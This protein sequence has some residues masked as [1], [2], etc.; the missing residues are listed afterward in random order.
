MEF[1]QIPT[2][3]TGFFIMVFVCLAAGVYIFS[4]VRK[5][6]MSVLRD[7][8]KDL[9]ATLTDNNTRI[10]TLESETKLLITKVTTLEQ[11]N[12]T[13]EDLVVTALK[14]YFFENPKVASNIK[15]VINPSS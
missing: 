1:L 6:D 7:A 4:N 8:N 5:N 14:Q 11:H 3:L 9:R 2:N 15:D 10:I 13:L 12:K